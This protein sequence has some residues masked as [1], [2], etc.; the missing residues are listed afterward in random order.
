M[1]IIVL[2]VAEIRQ[3]FMCKLDFSTESTEASDQ[4]ATALL[5]RKSICEMCGTFSLQKE[6]TEMNEHALRTRSHVLT[7][8]D[9][10]TC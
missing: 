2:I 4:M 5:G 7:K 8:D 3:R 6:E 10:I 1:L 9:R